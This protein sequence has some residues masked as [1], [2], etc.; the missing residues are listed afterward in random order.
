MS[1]ADTARR[2]KINVKTKRGG[3]DGIPLMVLNGGPFI[4]T[5]M[6]VDQVRYMC[7]NLSGI[8]DA[9]SEELETDT[10]WKPRSITVHDAC[11]DK[12][13]SIGRWDNDSRDFM[14]NVMEESHG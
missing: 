12:A 2:M 6:T 1:N 4:N 10:G 11:G 5:V 14:T 3:P 9:I 8:A 13:P 7:A